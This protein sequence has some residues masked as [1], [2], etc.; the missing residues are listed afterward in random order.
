MTEENLN[1]KLAAILSADVVGYSRLMG[2]DEEHTVN[3]ITA[4][5]KILTEVVEKNHGRV[6]DSPGDNILADFSSALNAV[7]SAIEIQATLEA[8][9]AELPKNRQMFFRIGIN[10]GDI[11]HKD[12]RIYGDGVNIAA[13]IESLANPGGISIS[14]DV[15]NQV[16]NKV[17]HDF[18]YMG[19]HAVKNI[20]EPVRIYRI[21]L[22]G[23]K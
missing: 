20:A 4:Y 7:T 16:K 2:D 13:R 14:G 11:I 3:T 5:R 15:Y 17:G 12:G 21:S 19:A 8:R 6:V 18:E 9:N 22:E 23:E 1:R 10:L